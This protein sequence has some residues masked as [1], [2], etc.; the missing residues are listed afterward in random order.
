MPSEIFI[1]YFTY[2]SASLLWGLYFRRFLFPFFC[3]L[4]VWHLF[5]YGFIINATSTAAERFASAQY[6]WWLPL[7]IVMGVYSGFAM[8]SARRLRR[9]V[10]SRNSDEYGCWIYLIVLNFIAM[11]AVLAL[12][13][14]SGT[15]DP[16]LNYWLVFVFQLVII[17]AAYF[18]LRKM[19]LWAS[20]KT[21]ASDPHVHYL[22][23]E[24]Y[25]SE[26]F[27]STETVLVLT[28]TLIFAI[29]QGAFPG[30]WPFWLVLATF[31][32]HSIIIT[33]SRSITKHGSAISDAYNAGRESVAKAASGGTL[34]QGDVF[35]PSRKVSERGLGGGGGYEMG[36][37]LG[38]VEG[39]GGADGGAPPKT[40]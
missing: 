39:G 14:T 1:S 30:V 40:L 8:A 9:V 24:D 26:T 2:Y 28:T 20:T 34:Q 35:K 12:W 11:L 33:I 31:G 17:V 7:T 16:P 13:D 3:L 32:F 19:T 36:P 23:F 29:F 21:H 37:L 4:G 38:D 6:R 15:I 27:R 22:S 10:F 18:I 25:A 5:I